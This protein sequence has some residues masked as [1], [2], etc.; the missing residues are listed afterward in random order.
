MIYETFTI[1]IYLK[2]QYAQQTF[3]GLQD[4]FNVT[5][6]GLPRRLEDVFQIR[7]EDV[8]EDKKLLC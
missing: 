2:R 4:V 8:L 3:V 5:I 6:F 7:L 1:L